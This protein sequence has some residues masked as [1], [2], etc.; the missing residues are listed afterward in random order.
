[1]PE[2]V[3]IAEILASIVTTVVVVACVYVVVRL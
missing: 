3:Q 2:L 1:M